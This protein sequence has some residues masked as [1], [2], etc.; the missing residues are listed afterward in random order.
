MEKTLS[1]ADRKRAESEATV[2]LTQMLKRHERFKPQSPQEFA[3]GG[4]NA[5]SS[6]GWGFA[7]ST[8]DY[9]HEC[10]W[11][12]VANCRGAQ[13][14]A[15]V[16][17]SN[18]EQEFMACK[19]DLRSKDFV[20]QT[21]DTLSRSARWTQGYAPIDP[22]RRVPAAGQER[23]RRELQGHSQV[24]RERRGRQVSREA[25]RAP[26]THSSSI[27]Y[28]PSARASRE[29]RSCATGWPRTAAVPRTP[30]SCVPAV[31]RLDAAA[32]DTIR[33]GHFKSDCDYGLG[34]IRI[35]FKLQD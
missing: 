27:R 28:P 33:S 24:R 19:A 25:R 30:K 5:K 6:K 32:I 22:G 31:T 4:Q 3:R 18:N 21:V 10:A 20:T 26:S 11:N 15:F 7:A 14:L 23:D 1:A 16:D 35:A 8:I 34:S 13:R 12:L 29:M 9:H 17:V 2:I